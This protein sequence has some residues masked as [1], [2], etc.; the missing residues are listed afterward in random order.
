MKERPEAARLLRDMENVKKLAEKEA[1]KRHAEKVSGGAGGTGTGA[2]AGGGNTPA[3]SSSRNAKK[4]TTA[5][6]KSS[7]SSSR[8]GRHGASLTPAWK[9]PPPG[10]IKVYTTK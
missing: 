4:E 3:S 10:F 8:R 2:G 6:E 5:K 1:R 7:S 9:A